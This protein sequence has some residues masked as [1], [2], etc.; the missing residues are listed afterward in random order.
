MKNRFLKISV[1]V[2]LFLTIVCGCYSNVETSNSPSGNGGSE[3]TSSIKTYG[4]NEDV[5]VK[6]S[7][8][9]E[10]RIKLTGIKET[11]ER[12]KYSDKEA[13]KVIIID[14]EYENISKSS[15]L[16]VSSLDFKGY[17]SDSTSLESYEVIT[18]KYPSTI[19]SGRKATAQMVWAVNN[20]TDKIELEYYDNM[21]NS[22]P[23]CKFNLSW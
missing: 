23:D 17:D 2:V 20:G 22:K 21:F 5:Y 14:Y 18:Y 3:S 15:D 19:S 11:K 10:Y 8:G 12:N 7:S 4:L 16:Y 1:L 13:K 9:E 6:N